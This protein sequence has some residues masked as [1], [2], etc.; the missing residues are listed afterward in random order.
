M[1]L[2][3]KLTQHEM[4]MFNKEKIK[5]TLFEVGFMEFKLVIDS[6]ANEVEKL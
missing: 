1:H 2:R 4:L 5:K 3:I 6:L